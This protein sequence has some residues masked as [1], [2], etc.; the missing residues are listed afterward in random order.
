MTPRTLR[1]GQRCEVWTAPADGGQ[2]ELAFVTAE[3]LFEAP[4]W[5]ADGRLLLNG[6]GRLWFLAPDGGGPEPLPATGLPPVNNDH[7]PAPDGTAAFCSADD[8]HIYRVPL[9]GGAAERVTH[10]DGARHF[11]HGVSPADGGRLA[12][13]E[14][15]DG[16]V[17]RRGRL[18]IL[19][20]ADGAVALPDVGDGHCDGPEFTP[21]GAWILLNTESFGRVAGHARPPRR[22]PGARG[23]GRP[24]RLGRRASQDR[25][26]RRPGDHERQQLGA[27]QQPVRVRRLPDRGRAPIRRVRPLREGIQ[28]SPRQ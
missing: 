18:A 21:D 2:P 8:G 16:D 6:G 26:V 7:V 14:I 9:A 25:G 22:R 15:H 12:Y 3:T 11:L 19:D 23:P 4:N 17:R 1:H 20:L 27:R 5:L 24:C 10:D 28:P 13:V